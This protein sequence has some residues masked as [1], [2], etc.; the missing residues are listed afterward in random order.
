L[1]AI[2]SL[3]ILPFPWT[4]NDLL[5]ALTMAR[6]TQPMTVAIFSTFRQFGSNIDPIAP[7]ALFPLTI[8][9]V[10]GSVE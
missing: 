3:A 9:I 1:P 5:V 6:T 8:P 10:A 4:C 2:A 7:A